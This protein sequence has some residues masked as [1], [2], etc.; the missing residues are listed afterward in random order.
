MMHANSSRTSGFS[1]GA[2]NCEAEDGEENL[3][4]G[5]EKLQ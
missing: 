4:N 3:A 2:T 1:G 5:G